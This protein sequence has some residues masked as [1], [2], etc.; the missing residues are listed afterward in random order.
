MNCT[1][2]DNLLKFKTHFM[3]L[4]EKF[5]SEKITLFVPRVWRVRSLPQDFYFMYNIWQDAGKRT[6][7]AATA[8]RCATNELHTS[9][10]SP[11]M[12]R[13]RQELH[14]PADNDDFF[15]SFFYPLHLK[16]SQK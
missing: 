1:L 5:S 14:P 7:V 4:E 12:R 8:A 16:N 2:E 13:T 10:N 3:Q 6:R 11:V 15:F 9:P